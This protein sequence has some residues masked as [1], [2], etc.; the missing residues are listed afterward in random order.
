MVSPAFTFERLTISSSVGPAD[1]SRTTWPLGC[2]GVVDGC[3]LGW[4]AGVEDATG[5]SVEADFTGLS[6]A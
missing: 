3:G 5:R 1:G 2:V 4:F 6:G